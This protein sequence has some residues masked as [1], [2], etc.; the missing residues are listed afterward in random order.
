MLNQ[1]ARSHVFCLPCAGLF[2]DLH[3][4]RWW[5]LHTATIGNIGSLPWWCSTVIPIRALTIAVALQLWLLHRRPASNFTPTWDI[6][7]WKKPVLSESSGLAK[8]ISVVIFLGKLAILT[9]KTEKMMQIYTKKHQKGWEK[10]NTK[11]QLW[12]Q[13]QKTVKSAQPP[14]PQPTQQRM[15]KGERLQC[16]QNLTSFNSQIFCD[17]QEASRLTFTLATS[18]HGVRLVFPPQKWPNWPVQ[19]DQTLEL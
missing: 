13:L 17:S 11:Q 8:M 16:T 19:W 3:S 6:A 14:Q 4:C 12:L 2:H 9:N 5:T 1:F 7:N 10:N 15:K 18:T